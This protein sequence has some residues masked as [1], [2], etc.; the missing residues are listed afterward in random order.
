LKDIVSV[1]ESLERY[2]TGSENST[3]DLILDVMD[4]LIETD[5]YKQ[6]FGKLYEFFERADLVR[7]VNGYI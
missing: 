7:K 5:L 1:V 6:D 4:V 2:I 3:K